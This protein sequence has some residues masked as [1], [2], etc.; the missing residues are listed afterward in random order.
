MGGAG[1]SVRLTTIDVLI[2][3]NHGFLCGALKGNVTSPK[4]FE[5]F[6]VASSFLETSLRGV[7]LY[8]LT[9]MFLGF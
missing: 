6:N 3:H 5:A 9:L 1:S 4:T 2:P 7:F 8:G